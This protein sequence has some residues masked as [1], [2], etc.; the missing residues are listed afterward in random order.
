MKAFVIPDWGDCAAQRSPRLSISNKERHFVSFDDSQD[1]FVS[2][3]AEWAWYYSELENGK[4]SQRSSQIQSYNS[5]PDQ[6]KDRALL[7]RVTILEGLEDPDYEFYYVLCG[8]EVP[9]ICDYCVKVVVGAHRVYIWNFRMS[10]GDHF[11]GKECRGTLLWR[12]SSSSI[13][14]GRKPW[15]ITRLDWKY[16]SNWAEEWSHS[17]CKRGIQKCFKRLILELAINWRAIIT[18]CILTTSLPGHAR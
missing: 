4:E 10:T 13:L 7:L 8:S 1:F 6:R 18:R 15:I 11:F 17:N 2:H 5:G 14:I 3:H 12:S 9:N 16:L